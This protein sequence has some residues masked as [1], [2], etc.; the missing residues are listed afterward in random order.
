MFFRLPRL[1]QVSH[2][3]GLPRLNYCSFPYLANPVF[4]LRPAGSLLSTLFRGR[5]W[6]TVDTMIHSFEFEGIADLGKGRLSQVGNT[7]GSLS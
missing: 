6:R 3:V 7:I 4:C 5:E 1:V 2:G